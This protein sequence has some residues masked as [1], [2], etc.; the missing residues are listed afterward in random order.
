ML[1]IKQCRAA[2]VKEA[3]KVQGFNQVKA[4]PFNRV[5]DAKFL[6]DFPGLKVPACLIVFLGRT[7]TAKGA[8]LD[9]VCQWTAIVVAKDAGGGAWQIVDDLVDAFEEKVL[10]QQLLGDELTVHAS[11]TVGVAPTAPR[12]SVYEVSFTTREAGAR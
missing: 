4:Y 10:D 5:N 12:F 7:G 2:L 3:K 6:K 1:S 11:A 9:R 8:A